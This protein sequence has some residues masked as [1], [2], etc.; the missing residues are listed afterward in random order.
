M[1]ALHEQPCREQ[2]HVI[3]LV[4]SQSQSAAALAV[5]QVRPVGQPLFQHLEQAD[6][7]Q[8]SGITGWLSTRARGATR[9][10]ACGRG[11]L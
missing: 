11:N 2:Q 6:V 9:R 1:Q 4:L 5:K 10:R 3:P 7:E 8:L